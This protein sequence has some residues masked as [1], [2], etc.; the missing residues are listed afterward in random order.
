[1]AQNTYYLMHHGVKGMRWGVRR[2][3]EQLGHRTFGE[4]AKTKLNDPEFKRKAA[5]AAK[6]ALVVGAAYST[7]KLI[8]NPQAVKVGKEMLAKVLKNSGSI[9]A[10]VANSAE[11]K[12]ALAV[13]KVGKK[14]LKV[15]SSEK[16]KSTVTGI[17]AMAGTAAVLRGQIKDFRATKSEGDA[18]DKAVY[19]IQKGSEIGASINNL[20][21]GPGGAAAPS[22][23]TSSSSSN[24][25][26]KQY[27]ATL[28]GGIEVKT[29]RHMGSEEWRQLRRY[30]ENHPGMSSKEALDELGW[31]HPDE[32]R[33]S[34]AKNTTKE[35]TNGQRSS[36]RQGVL[37][38]DSS[39]GKTV[40]TNRPVT[41]KDTK[42]IGDYRK[43]HPNKSLEEALD[44]LGLL[45]KHYIHHSTISTGW[46]FN[47]S[48]KNRYI[49]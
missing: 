35:Q 21:K 26:G 33:H 49:L 47:T 8:N 41:L 22:Q 16:F 13:G 7:H 14:A 2:T 43:S 48:Y 11:F 42:Q 20:A 32:V 36:S 39:S 10:S 27:K 9:K 15:V 3:P 31:L 28:P 40:R 45:D 6:I 24:D 23:N 44:D 46:R 30:K 19:K 1:M 38:R 25:S 34:G 37:M 18:F 4:K 12:A 29:T 17:G 5:K